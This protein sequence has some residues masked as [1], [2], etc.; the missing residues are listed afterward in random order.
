M[1]W[2]L[3]MLVTLALAACGG[4]GG[5][6]SDAGSAAPASASSVAS[7]ISGVAAVGAAIQGRVYV[8]DA[9]GHERFVDTT[10]GSYRFSLLGMRPPVLL[11]AQWIDVAGIHRL[12]SFASADGVANITPLTHLAVG[13]AAGTNALDALYASPSPAAFEALKNALPG[14]IANLQTA[15][16]PLL[17]RHAI[18]GANPITYHFA[19]DHTGMDGLLDSITV[20]YSGGNVTLTDKLTGAILLSAPLTQLFASVGASSWGI[21]D[22]SVATDTDVAIDASGLGL[23]TWTEL[24]GGHSVLKARLMNGVDT[25]LTLSTADASQPHV[26]YDAAGNAVLVW[27]QLGNGRSEI[28]SSRYSAADK[29]WTVARTLSSAAAPGSANLPDLALDQAG[30]ALVVWTQ[31]NGT[32]NHFDAWGAQYF[33]ATDSWS[34]PVLLSDDVNNAF[35]VH[36]AVN[37]S[38]QGLMAWQQERGDGSS[39][40]TQPVDIWARIISTTGPHGVANRV[41][42]NASGVITAA[43]VYGQLDVA[44]S[45]NGDGAVLWS[46]RALPS[47]PMTVQAALFNAG[48]G[49]QAAAAISPSGTD[50]C[51][52]PRIAFDAAGNALAVW[53]QQTDHGAYGGTN[54]YGAG[55][56]WGTA[57]IFVDSRLGDTLAPSLAMDAAGDATVVW[58]RW[59]SAN[60][61]DVMINR[62]LPG[63]GWTGAQVFAPVGVDGSMMR[64]QP[65]VVANASG[66]TVVVWG[67]G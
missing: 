20:L 65:R 5:G 41:N 56:G 58:Y 32:V 51:Y 27:T 17:A 1:R 37:N 19:V 10:D 57:S 35:G 6:G 64:T 40:S 55:A 24:R 9:S 13:S 26:A 53:Q 36:L 61:I 28:W 14:A 16:Q 62:S 59:T 66:Q 2:F 45:A 60:V 18:N 39:N 43:Y 30:N 50:D 12:Y 46:Q 25:G 31:A 22:A 67:G 47:L 63:S 44:V 42:V 7:A 15:L 3:T 8:L 48:T 29:H 33:V 11:K 38:G 54:R 52:A 21:S 23:V 4:G 34:S 49:W